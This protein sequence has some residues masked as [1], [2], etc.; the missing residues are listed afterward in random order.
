MATRNSEY[1]KFSFKEFNPNKE[2]W[3]NYYSIFEMRCKLHGLRNDGDESKKIHLLNYIGVESFNLLTD[4]FDTGD[5]LSVPFKNI[6]KCL[7]NY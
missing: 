6:L 2:S 3:R 5:L 7:Q 4:I 1:N